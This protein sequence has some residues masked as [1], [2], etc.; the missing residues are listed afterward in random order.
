MDE[1]RQFHTNDLVDVN[2][3]FAFHGSFTIH[4]ALVLDE[5]IVFADGIDW[6]ACLSLNFSQREPFLK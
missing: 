5:G 3:Y 4:I 6:K 2:F 1:K